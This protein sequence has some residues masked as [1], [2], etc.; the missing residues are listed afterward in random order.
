MNNTT[1]SLCVLVLAAGASRRMRG[2][3]K[4]LEQVDGTALLHRVALLALGT[5]HPVLLTLPP[6]SPA[7]HAALAGLPVQILTVAAAQEGMAASLRAGMAAA[8]E[9]SASLL[10]LADM[11]EIDAQD[12]AAMIHA[13]CATPEMILRGATAAGRAGHPVLF[14]AWARQGL[15]QLEGDSGAKPFL[16]AHAARIRLVPLPA[17]HATTD[18]DTPEDW[19]AWR[20]AR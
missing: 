16:Q 7:R 9:G 8:P 15:M 18:L 14:P 12:L 4:L 5:G 10:L 6:D 11:P 1:P 13:H 3:D 2:T 20:A 17:S 19:A